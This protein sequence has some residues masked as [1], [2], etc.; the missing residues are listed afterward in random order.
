MNYNVFSLAETLNNIIKDS[1]EEVNFPYQEPHM[2]VD[3]LKWDENIKKTVEK[4]LSQ[5]MTCYQ[6]LETQRQRNSQKPKLPEEIVNA[7]FIIELSSEI[8]KLMFAYTPK[9]IGPTEDVDL[10]GLLIFNGQNKYK[11]QMFDQLHKILVNFLKVGKEIYD[12]IMAQDYYGA[13]ARYRMLIET[14]SIFSFFTNHPDC[15]AKFR[16]QAIVKQHK[17]LK[18]HNLPVKEEDEKLYQE[19][20]KK[21]TQKERKGIK[22][23]YWWAGKYI[24]EHRSI[25]EIMEIALHSKD[26]IA[27]MQQDYNFYSEYSHISSYVVNEPTSFNLDYFRNLTMRL[28]DMHFCIMELYVS[29]LLD[30]SFMQNSPLQDIVSILKKLREKICGYKEPEMSIKEMMEKQFATHDDRPLYSKASQKDKSKNEQ[31]KK[32][33]DK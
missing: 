14:Y 4:F 1:L 24:K 29:W 18:S 15:I 23:N 5:R 11:A 10:D 3:I 6:I 33:E 19:T 31:D 9:I 32:T 12:L 13:I 25:K 7:A 2:D 21:Y 27:Y 26:E 16:D 28:I 30:R 17:M 22:W 20:I 8:E